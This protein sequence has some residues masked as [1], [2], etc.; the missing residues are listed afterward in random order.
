MEYNSTT[1]YATKIKKNVHS[2]TSLVL[3]LQV[4]NFKLE[5]HGTRQG[6]SQDLETG[7]RKLAI[8]NL[9]GVQIL[10]GTTIYSNFNH[11]HVLIIQNKA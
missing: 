8:V 5:K 9:L 2:H 3:A 10:R 1:V 7:C 4:F 11:K 6:L